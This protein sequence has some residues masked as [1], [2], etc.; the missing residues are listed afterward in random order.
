MFF[1]G[2]DIAKRAHE[3]IVIDADGKV[4]QKSFSFKNSCA[5]YNLL[6]EHV[7]QITQNRAQ[8]LFGMESTAHY[9]LALYT[10]LKK[11]GYTVHVINPLQS[12]A[13]RNLYIRQNKTDS[14]DSLIIADVIRFGRFSETLVP[15]ETQVALRELCRN[16]FYMVD[17]VSD[18]KRKVVALLDQVFPEFGS[19]F[20]SV[21]VLSAMEVLSK[22]PTPEKICRVNLET[23]T[24]IFLKHSNGYFGKAKAM[25]L[26]VAAKTSFGVADIN[27]VYSDLIRNYIETIRSSKAKV[28]AFDLKIKEIMDA[29]DSPITS[30]TGIGV[31]L[32]AT[33]LSEIGNISR[34]RS[35]DKLVAYAGIDP[36]VKQ[37]GNFASTQNHMSKRGSPYLRRAIWMACT[38]AWRYDPMFRAYYDKKSSEGLRY[39]N[40]IGHLTKKMT[41]VIFAVLRDNKPYIPHFTPITG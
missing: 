2:I 32:G 16:R 13:L 41:A 5:G 18:L 39:M 15:Q 36:T 20:S 33:I 7:R 22:Y 4:L 21:F 3:A 12:D 38:V 31:T 23:L 14:K 11:D 40:I 1:I 17:S 24:K 26:K 34:F 6:L 9:W 27:G 29:L 28:E 35:S 8:L 10:R 19:L 30:I 37:S 25:E